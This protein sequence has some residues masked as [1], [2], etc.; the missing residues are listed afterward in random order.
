MSGDVPSKSPSRQPPLSVVIPCYN[1]EMNIGPVVAGVRTQMGPEVEVIVVDDGSSDA[2]ARIAAE[3]GARVVRHAYNIGNGAAW[4]SGIRAAR[5]RNIVIMDGD[6]QHDP[7]DITRLV[8]ALDDYHMVVG[9]R[10]RSSDT[11]M[12]RDVANAVFNAFATY[13]A[14]KRIEDLTSG[15]RAFRGR[16]AKQFAYLLP[17][18]FSSPSTITLATIRAGYSVRYEPIVVKRRKGKSKIRPLRDATRFF[19][20]MLKVSTLF[21]PLRVFLPAAAL[22]FVAGAGYY[23]FTYI[24]S[25][26]FT[27]MSALLITNSVLVFLLGMISEQI[28]QLR[29]DRSEEHH[30]DEE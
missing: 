3:A 5:G 10:T 29:L 8:A 23:A 11:D 7:A 26:R 28:A 18:T 30:L 20:I 17:N 21:S 27:N 6:G 19:L 25:H 9:A 1:E 2:T 14:K 13:L 22:F 24:T 16:L 12:H 15:F 4:K